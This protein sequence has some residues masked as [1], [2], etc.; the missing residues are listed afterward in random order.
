M[1]T[2]AAFLAGTTALAGIWLGLAVAGSVAARPAPCDATRV[3]AALRVASGGV[4]WTAIKEIIAVGTIAEPAGSG[5]VRDAR[6]TA[7][8]RNAYVEVLDQGRVT[9]VYDGKMKWE[10]GQTGSVH[11]LNAPETLSR[12]VTGAYLDRNGLW[13]DSQAAARITCLPGRSEGSAQFDVLRV[14]PEHG[15]RVDIWIDRS[16]H[17]I[18]RISEQQPA[19]VSTKRYADYREVDGLALPFTIVRHF[20]DQYGKPALETQRVREYRLL[21]AVNRADFR[22]PSRTPDTRITGSGASAPVSFTIDHGAIVFPVVLDGHGPFAFTFDPGAPGVL[23]VIASRA[24]GLR[25]AG[26]A[27]VHHV[28]IGAAEIASLALPV[29]GGSA[30][31]IFPERD[32]RLPAIAGSLGP[33]MLDRFAVRIDYAARTLTLT[34]LDEFRYRGNGVAVPFTLQDDD[35]IP[36]LP[37]RIDGHAGS[38][39]YDVRAPSALIVFGPFQERTGLTM[40]DVARLEIGGVVLPAVAA[41]FSSARAG[42]FASRTEAG[43]AG[44]RVVSQFTATLDYRSHTA[45]IER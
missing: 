27:A 45:F 30:A 32:P 28:R 11:G 16:T 44:Y 20:V 4:R 8:G 26:F 37:A 35:D 9:Y 40:R 22:E 17:L 1:T 36:L 31:D 38:V 25:N 42:K 23:T 39:Q 21:R 19:T 6:D 15:S 3:I 18:D 41:R 5:V 7:T 2:R 24:L 29:Y 14:N 13:N 33:E 12:A 10:Q 34:P 43:L